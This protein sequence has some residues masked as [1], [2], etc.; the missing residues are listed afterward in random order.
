VANDVDY[1]PCAYLSSAYLLWWSTC[2][3]L[4]LITGRESGVWG[5]VGG[6]RVNGEADRGQKW[7]K[8]FVSIYVNRTMKPLEIVLRRV[9]GMRENDGGSESHYDTL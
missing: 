5:P 9:K 3:D 8:W 2:P 7:W 4:L 1:F 6:W